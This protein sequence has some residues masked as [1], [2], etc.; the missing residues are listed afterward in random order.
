MQA[1]SHCMPLA[2]QT[3]H[4]RLHHNILQPN[5]PANITTKSLQIDV[6]IKVN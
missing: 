5:L 6:T 2:A 1:L 3:S 4:G